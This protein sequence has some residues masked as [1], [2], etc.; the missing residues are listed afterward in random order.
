MQEITIALHFKTRVMQVIAL[1]LHLFTIVLRTNE[2]ELRL[3]FLIMRVKFLL[4]QCRNIRQKAKEPDD[5]SDHPALL[6]ITFYFNLP[7]LRLFL[8]HRRK[9]LQELLPDNFLQ[10][11]DALRFDVFRLFDA[12]WSSNSRL[13]EPRRPR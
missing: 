7:P 8:P 9:C 12:L 2:I 5:R 13:R 4:L 1:A 10:R 6:L 3:K 11:P